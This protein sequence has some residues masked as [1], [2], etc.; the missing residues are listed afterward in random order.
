MQIKR[1]RPFLPIILEMRWLHRRHKW[2]T[3]MVEHGRPHVDGDPTVWIHAQLDDAMLDLHPHGVLR[4]QPL[5]AHEANETPGTVTTVFDLAA[6][7]VVDDV[8]KVDA[9]PGRGAHRED[10]VSAHTEMPVGQK[11]VLGSGEPERLPCFIEHDKV[12]ARS[13]HFGEWDAHGGSKW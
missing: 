11:P 12:V 9:R 7:R 2:H 1:Q 4:G 10:L 3:G 5:L 8:F 13:L 6:I